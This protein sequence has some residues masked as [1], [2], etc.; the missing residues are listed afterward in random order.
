M[1]EALQRIV[2]EIEQAPAG[3]TPSVARIYM[4]AISAL[5]KEVGQ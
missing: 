5:N 1:R 4:I 2:D 3:L